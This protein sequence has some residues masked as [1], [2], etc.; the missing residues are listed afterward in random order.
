MLTCVLLIYGPNSQCVDSSNVSKVCVHARFISCA[1]LGAKLE[2][3]R[4]RMFLSDC[5][6]PCAVQW[7]VFVA[8]GLHPSGRKTRH[9]NVCF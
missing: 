8:R 2:R 7:G 3:T 6:T 1:S 4:E 5:P 9:Q